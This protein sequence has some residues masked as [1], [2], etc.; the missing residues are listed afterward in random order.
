[1]FCGGPSGEVEVTICYTVYPDGRILVEAD[2]PGV[3]GYP[4]LPV[5]AMDFCTK[6]KLN[7]VSYLGLGPWE[8]YIDRAC[9]AKLGSFD[10]TATG[11]LSFYLRP[12]ECGN[13]MGVR[14]L[15]V[16]NE[17]GTCGL[18][19]TSADAPFEMSVLPYSA[20]E[21]EEAN[22]IYELPP[23][24]H[25]WVRIASQQMG[26]GGDDSWGAPVHEEYRIDSSKPQHLAFWITPLKD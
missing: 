1:M 19:F 5:F 4:E 21:L 17:D 20:Y 23:V 12:Q 25:T 18:W 22:R 16:M 7:W 10:F 26:V 15:G 11:N 3:K 14:K 9:G 24:R 13:R 2:F 8:N 6:A